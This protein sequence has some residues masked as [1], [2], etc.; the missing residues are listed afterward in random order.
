MKDETIDNQQERLLWWLGGIIDGE[1][2]ITI[3]HHM[4]YHRHKTKTKQSLLFAP[5]IIIVNTNRI[6]IDKCQEILRNAGIAFYVTYSPGK[7]KV[8]EKWS[9]SIIGIKRCVRAL[10]IISHY[11]IGKREEAN[12]VKEFCETRLA[13]NG[14]TSS[15]E[16]MYSDR[17]FEIIMRVAKIHNRNPQ[18]LYAEICEHKKRKIIHEKWIE[19]RN[20][21]GQF[22]AKQDIV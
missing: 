7:E 6:L 17:D 19:Q 1:G 3:N 16:R 2:C 9:I 5:A 21:K 14:K 13:V 18:R 10:N 20:K 12:L 4:M 8:K 11:L 22:I 15:L